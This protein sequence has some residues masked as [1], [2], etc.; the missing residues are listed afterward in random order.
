MFYAQ[1]TSTVIS[2]RERER[3][4][5]VSS[6][7]SL[8]T[9][10]LWRD[11]ESCF[12]T[13]QF[14]NPV[15]TEREEGER[16]RVVSSL[17]SLAT[18]LLQREKRERERELFL[19]CAVWQPCYYRER[20]GRERES[21]FFTAQFGNPVITQTEEGERESVVS[22]LRSLATLLLERERERERELFLHCAVW[23]PFY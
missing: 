20:R 17:R 16:E 18:L 2:G 7:R 6:L 10:L 14:G 1:S 13:A 3:N 4:S 5:C 9:L 19:H 11:R 21:C 15:I 23:Q 12:F 8:V 22:S